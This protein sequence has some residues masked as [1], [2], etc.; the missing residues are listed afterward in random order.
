M[1][2]EKEFRTDLRRF[3][4]FKISVVLIAV[5]LVFR[6][7]EVQAIR[8]SEYINKA[9]FAKQVRLEAKRGEIFDRE[10]NPLVLNKPTVSLGINKREIENIDDAVAKLA[11][12]LDLSED[13]MRR[14]LTHGSPFVWIARRAPEILVKKIEALDISG[15]QRIDEWRRGYP[16]GRTASHLLGFTG[17][18][19]LGLSG[20]EYSYDE[21]LKGE[22]GM[23]IVYLD[24]TGKVYKRADSPLKE[25]VS[26]RNINLTIQQFIQRICEEELEETVRRHNA[27]GGSVIVVQP[28]TGHVL[29]MACSPSYDPAEGTKYYPSVWR[30]RPVTD[31]H[32]MGSVMKAF[33]FA[34]ALEEKLRDPEEMVFCENG[35]Y[36]IYDQ[37]IEDHEPYGWL[38]ARE[39]LVRSSN[40][41]MAKIGMKMPADIIYK[42]ERDFGFGVLT[43][44]GLQGEARGVLPKLDKWSPFSPAAMSYGYEVSA[45]PL[46]VAMAYAAIANKGILMKPIILQSTGS[47]DK[48]NAAMGDPE[49]IRRV[50]SEKTAEALGKILEEVVQEGTGRN[51]NIPG[52]RIA[53]K[54]GTAKKA[55][56]GEP[57]YREGEYISSFAGYSMSNDG[58]AEY[59]IYVMI[60]SPHEVFYASDVAAPTFKRILRRIMKWQGDTRAFSVSE[61]ESSVERVERKAVVLPTFIHRNV[62]TTKT[63][64]KDLGIEAEWEGSG[65]LIIDQNP[66]PGSRV[67]IGSTVALRLQKY[68]EPENIYMLTPKVIGLTARE[69][70]NRLAL[71][72]IH[73]EVSGTGRV[74]QQNPRPGDRIKKGENCVLECQSRVGLAKVNEW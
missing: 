60:D 65:D 31:A 66:A 29:A 67:E 44:I 32:E 26:G 24:A 51:A 10:N 43:S 4:S 61:E 7:V 48:R 62:K 73:A 59:C 45:T 33:V 23:S 63:L 27:A 8:R 69:A 49:P 46:Q 15:L 19:N 74:I 40:I 58:D 28:S 21:L 72:D 35:E 70:I 37:E 41:G 42:Y 14:K 57:G 55:K 12:V 39:V 68:E 30:L 18:D 20:I 9:N 17:V 5:I 38:T 71:L 22:A 11:P 53:G 52:V 47:G 64:L 16:H 2:K 13:V 50:I 1:V 25:P 34:A 56:I 3:R 54:T 36:Q 6:L